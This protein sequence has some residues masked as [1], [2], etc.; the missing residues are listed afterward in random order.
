MPKKNKTGTIKKFKSF[1]LPLSPRIHKFRGYNGMLVFTRS[2][3]LLLGAIAV[4][5]A[6]IGIIN[7]F[8]L[9]N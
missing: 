7:I 6:A 8:G 3:G 4:D 5:L 2:M 9:G 1:Y